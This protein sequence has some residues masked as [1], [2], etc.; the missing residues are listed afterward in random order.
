MAQKDSQATSAVV[1]VF[2]HHSDAEEAVRA[3]DKGGI[4]MNK[5]SIIGRDFQLKEDVQ[6][7]YHPSD[8][9]KEGADFG[10]WVGGLFGLLVVAG[11]R[12]EIERARQ[13]LQSTGQIEMEQYEARQ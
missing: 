9:A 11:T 12:E 6:G 7:Y 5:I 10:A 2:R 1:A 3:L 13:I 8:A 4:P